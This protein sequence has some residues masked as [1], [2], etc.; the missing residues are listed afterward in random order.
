LRVRACEC[1]RFGIWRC[2]ESGVCQCCNWMG[3]IKAHVPAARLMP[4]SAPPLV[5]QLVLVFFHHQ[6]A[7]L[8]ETRPV[9]NPSFSCA[10]RMTPASPSRCAG[11]CP[12]PTSPGG[13]QPTRWCRQ[14][15]S[16]R[17]W[18]TPSRWMHRCWC[19]CPTCCTTL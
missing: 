17:C 14:L 9:P 16:S 1:T 3:F 11:L 8:A 6:G 18:L 15:P 10:L 4:C 13:T 2:N 12:T 19:W 7:V 5:T